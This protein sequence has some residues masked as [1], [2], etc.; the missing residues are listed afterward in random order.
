MRRAVLAT[1]AAVLA[2]GVAS[3]CT[4]TSSPSSHRPRSVPTGAPS[5]PVT[6]APHLEV[7]RATFRLPTPIARE[8][9]IVDGGGLVVAGGLGAGDTSLATAY[10]LDVQT[11]AIAR[12]PAL[13][14]PVH[15][16]AGALVSGVPLV[17]GGGNSAEQGV[18]QAGK[19]RRWRVIGHL[20]RPRSDLV[21][22][23]L[24][25]RVFAIGGYDG[26][27]PAEPDILSSTDGRH[28]SSV[29]T[30]PRPVRY[31]AVAVAD[32]AIWLIGGEVNGTMQTAIQRIDPR[33]GKARVVG[34]LP[35][36]LGHAVAVPLGRRILVVGGRTAK[37][38]V[39]DRLLWFD[40]AT[41]AVRP[42][43]HLP[44]PLADAGV[45]VVGQSAYLLGGETPA[46]SRQ[47]LAIG[48]R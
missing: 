24:G 8:A 17:I 44:M 43:G 42:A 3:G 5:R 31:A 47:V 22:V 12:I 39:T 34:H 13:P 33:T 2:T 45:A 36:G 27:R 20:P 10:R 38:S 37:N 19:G 30:L 16:T 9:V 7:R 6:P 11:G 46:L 41:R 23:S 18:V 4:S 25:G 21:T 15:D 1:L 28:W 14:V 32:G 29:G 40:P 26:T 48:Y 35:R